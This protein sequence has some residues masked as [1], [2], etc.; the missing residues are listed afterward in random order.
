MSAAMTKK[1]LLLPSQL[2]FKVPATAKIVGPS[3]IADSVG[4]RE[5]VISQWPSIK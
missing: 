2:D 3:T 5:A 4:A 1:K